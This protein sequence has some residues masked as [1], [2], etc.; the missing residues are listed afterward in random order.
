M[1]KEINT[2]LVGVGALTILLILTLIPLYILWNAVNMFSEGCVAEVDI[3]GPLTTEEIPATMFSEGKAGSETIAKK[4]REL[5]NRPDV[6]AV[7][8]V[9]NS[10][11]GTIVASK[12][13]Y[14][15]IKDLKKP[16]VVYFREIATSGGYY[17]ST[18]ADWIVSEPDALTAN[19]GVRAEMMNVAELMKNIGVNVTSIKKGEHKDIGNPFRNMTEEE[20]QIFESILNES[21]EEFKAVVMKHRGNK[22]KNIDEIFDSRIMTGRQAY[23]HGLVD[24]L[25]NKQDAINKA[26][27][28]GGIKGKPRVCKIDMTPERTLSGFFMESI[29]RFAQGVGYGFAQGLMTNEKTRTIKIVYG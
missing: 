2:F 17:I 26:A 16:K 19:I 6:K 1:K 23:K 12:E 25:G 10:P 4:I 29:T 13:I 27:E 24:Q 5:N 9:V 14:D 21:Y 18:P 3:T 11:G 15:A 28:L 8:I 22:L 7:V 20:R